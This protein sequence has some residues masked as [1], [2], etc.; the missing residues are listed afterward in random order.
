MDDYVS[1]PVKTEDLQAALGLPHL[2]AGD[3]LP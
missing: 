1:K 2:F 3:A